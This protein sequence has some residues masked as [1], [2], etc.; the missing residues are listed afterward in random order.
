MNEVT[1]EK[2]KGD[3]E[4]YLRDAVDNGNYTKVNMDKDKVA[5]VIEEPEWNILV[6]AMKMVLNGEKH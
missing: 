3:P 4:K 6:E 5:V 1:L 2:F